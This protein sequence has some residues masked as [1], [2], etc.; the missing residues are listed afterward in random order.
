MDH[1]PRFPFLIIALFLYL[2]AIGFG[3]GWNDYTFDIDDQYMV[4]RANSYDIHIY[5]KT[6]PYGVEPLTNAG[7][8]FEA[9]KN[10]GGP[11]YELFFD[12]MHIFAKC[13]GCK[14]RSETD[15]SLPSMLVT[16]TSQTYFFVI[17]KQSGKVTGPSTNGEFE[18]SLKRMGISK[19]RQWQTLRQ[20]YKQSIRDGRAD[21]SKLDVALFGQLGFITI[22]LTLPIVLITTVPAIVVAL[23][24]YLIK[25]RK[26]TKWGFGKS[27]LVGWGILIGLCLFG[28]MARSLGNW[29]DMKFL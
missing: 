8:K 14:D 22:V 6:G 18:A 9:G 17:D 15:P 1:A 16:D 12:D 19:P 20:A 10:P 11:L 25:R 29:F 26:G 4:L 24:I 21:E 5:K 27:W 7:A 2:P 23:P 13:W 28:M 3:S